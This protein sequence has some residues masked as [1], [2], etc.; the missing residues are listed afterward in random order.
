MPQVGLGTYRLRGDAV[1]EALRSAVCG[2]YRLID[3][4]TVYRNEQDIGRAVS[5]LV[6]DGIVSRADL[7]ITTKISPK[8]QGFESALASVRRSLA[9]LQTAYIDLV[10]IHW[11]GTAK[12]KP[13]DGRH[14]HNR[15]ETF[16]A[17]EQ[18]VKDGSVRSI[19]VSNYTARHLRT[20][21]EDQ[22]QRHGLLPAVHQYELHPL[23]RPDD[24]E[25]VC[26]DHGIAVQ[27][28]SSF[29]EGWFLDAARPECLLLYDIAGKVHRTVA[30]VLLRWAIQRGYAVIPKAS[31]AARIKENIQ[32][33]DF[34]LR[35]EVRYLA[36]LALCP[37][38]N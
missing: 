1:Q 28:Y 6:N 9:L 38:F 32:I 17:L 37:L 27:A 25:Q 8:D 11:P 5:Q 24:V 2:G 4:A 33:D 35:S 22:H 7:F 15:A 23:Y 16:R 36:I 34:E 31:S 18:C 19:G 29:G 26:H 14:A 12:L 21:I 13:D 10:L 3:T 30:Q 20:L